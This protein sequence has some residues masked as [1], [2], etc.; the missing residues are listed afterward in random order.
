MLTIIE[1]PIERTPAGKA[2]LLTKQVEFLLR[3]KCVTDVLIA[4][5]GNTLNEN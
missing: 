3:E 2:A 5:T 1:F 4:S